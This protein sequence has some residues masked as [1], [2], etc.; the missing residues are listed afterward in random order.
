MIQSK[1]SQLCSTPSDINQHLPT[2]SKYAQQAETIL[3]AGVRSVISTWAFMHGITQNNSDIKTIYSVDLEP[4]PIFEANLAAQV[5]NI[6]LIFTQSDILK[7]H[8]PEPV[9]I[10]FIDTLHCYGQLKR[11]LAIFAPLTKKYIIMHDTT[12]DEFVGEP[13]RMK[14]NME[15]MKKNTGFDDNDLVTGLWPAVEEFLHNNSDWELK[16]RFTNNNGL[17]ILAKKN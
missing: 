3:E 16:E 15:Q 6:K 7:Y 8:L 5:N 17:T 1:Y 9:D 10:A 14:Y 13:I 4:A 12:V 2:L 11:E